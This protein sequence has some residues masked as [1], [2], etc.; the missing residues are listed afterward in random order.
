MSASTGTVI[1]VKVKVIH[2]KGTCPYEHKVGDEWIVGY[3]TPPGI[4]NSAY[5]AIYPHIRVLQRGGHYELPKGSGVT[6]LG[7]PDA[8]N[9][10]IFEL[11]PIASTARPAPPLAAGTGNL[12][13]L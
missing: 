6:R 8:W 5:M 10:V 9:C 3:K 4:C 1:D 13:N 2:I 7:C 11:A 12:D